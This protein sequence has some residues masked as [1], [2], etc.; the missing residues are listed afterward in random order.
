MSRPSLR[1]VALLLLVLLPSMV[2]AADP[3][4]YSER[5]V[6]T[7]TLAP[8]EESEV[9]SATTVITRARIEETGATSVL[10]VL[11]LVPG[12]DVVRA[13]SDGAVTSVF[14]R[15]GSSAHALV[16]VDGI[17][18]NSPYFGGYDFS[19]TST[20]N[21]ERIEVVRGPFS[22]LYGSDAL[23]GVIQIFTRPP[24]SKAAVSGSVEAG[25][26]GSRGA[27]VFASAG[28][29]DAAIA[30]SVGDARTGGERAN[31]AWRGTSGSVRVDLHPSDS[32]S[33]SIEAEVRSAESEVPGAVGA[34]T[35]HASGGIREQRIAVPVTWKHDAGRETSLLVAT[36]RA[37]PTF[38]NP[39]DPFFSSSDSDAR[40][41]QLRATETWRSSR[42]TL[43][44]FASWDAWEVSSKTSYGPALDRDRSRIWAAG[45]QES[46]RLG[47]RWSA[48]GGIRY[49]RH[50]TF[51]G[52]LSPRGTVSRLSAGSRWKFRVSAGRAFRAPSIGE[53]YYPYSGNPELRPERSTTFEIG[54]ER[55]L[56]GGGRVEVS[57]FRSDYQDLILYDF[58]SSRNENVGRALSRGIEVAARWPVSRR[59][60]FD[61]GYTLLEAEDRLTGRDLPR[62]PRHRAY[63]AATAHPLDRLLLTV[64][65][66]F[67]GS[68]SDV[69]GVTFEPVK[70]PAY[71][72]LDL[73][74]RREF[75]RYSPF[76]RMDNLADR[77][78]AEADGYPAAG[79]RLA[80]GLDV[81][82]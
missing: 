5:V 3:P 80:F 10:E 4:P 75:A 43:V 19:S 57:A 8:E 23:G 59:L 54:L 26:A 48:T 74:A 40:T 56:K 30:I 82:M 9:G 62:R 14:L 78:Y 24:G 49:D 53:L 39:D 70:S 60:A 46:L 67:V 25:G 76:V 11:R 73:F 1:F 27:S 32:F 12:L 50:S 69:D 45:A 2:H 31:S 51:G 65:T 15:G 35:P 29:R 68:R 36:T 41:V 72:R 38:R 6:V 55:Y 66:T 42:R 81:R 58:P 61:A 71:F 17:R 7:A 77:R 34:E 28:V 18:V 47:D 79:R 20:A 16:L 64:T 63:V 52:E 13:G 44:A 33:A 21:V 22:A 37:E